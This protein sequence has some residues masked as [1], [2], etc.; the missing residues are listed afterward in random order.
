[1]PGP[2]HAIK[3][4]GVNVPGT[5]GT[6]GKKREQR[7]VR[8]VNRVFEL[9][10]QGMTKKQ[11][12]KEVHVTEPTL[13]KILHDPD[14]V[15][16]RLASYQEQLRSRLPKTMKA[17]DQILDSDLPSMLPKKAD[18]ALELL[19]MTQVVGKESPVNVF[20]R[21]GDT[22]INVSNDTLEAAR[23]VAAQMRAAVAPQLPAADVIDVDPIEEREEN[24][25]EVAMDQKE[26][27]REPGTEAPNND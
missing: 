22:H 13:E 24:S 23:A 27:F 11:I 9:R 8:L 6:H 21:G 4:D 26:D 12:C 16:R 20:I 19:R 17:V 25:N 15:R 14:H 2:N 7:L 18:I 10:E 1:M 5:G 3:Y